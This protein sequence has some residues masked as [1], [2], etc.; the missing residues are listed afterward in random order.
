MQDRDTYLRR[1]YG[2]SLGDYI[3]LR[4]RQG[5]VCAICRQVP[6][7]VVG[8]PRTRQAHHPELVVD[9]DHATGR[10]RGLL[11]N[12]CNISL[13]HARDDAAILSAMIEYLSSALPTDR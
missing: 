8:P 13:A 5:G 6:T 11:C 9:H 3:E 12:N 1:T 7:K 10:V 2:I 4:E